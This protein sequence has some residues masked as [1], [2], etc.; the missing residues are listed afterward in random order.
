MLTL[1]L[2]QKLMLMQVHNVCGNVRSE[3]RSLLELSE[4][5]ELTFKEQL[6]TISGVSAIW[7]WGQKR[8][9]MRIWIDPA[10]LAGYQLTPLM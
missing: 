6:Q 5:A 3:K 1:L 2:Y 10:K 7:I 9:A 4:M 8:Y